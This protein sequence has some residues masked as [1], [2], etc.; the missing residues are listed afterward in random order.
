MQ[1]QHSD[2]E[3]IKRASEYAISAHKRIDQRRK[4]TG[5]PYH[6]HLKAV[7][8]TVSEAGGDAAQVAAAWLHDTVEDTPATFEDIEMEFGK[9]IAT[10][11]EELT[12][13]SRPGDGN[14][15]KRKKIDRKH[16]AGISPRA[17][18]IKLADLIDNARD[19]LKHDLKFAKVYLAEMQMLLEVLGEGDARLF[20]RAQNALLKGQKK[21]GMDMQVLQCPD[22]EEEAPRSIFSGF[23]HHAFKRM[24]F[25]T[26]SAYDIAKPLLAFD[27]QTPCETVLQ[28]LETRGF[29]LAILTQSGEYTGYVKKQEITE[30]ICQHFERPIS[31]NQILEVNA[32]ISEAVYT[33][34]RYDV[35]FVKLFDDI[36]AVIS[37]DDMNKPAA[38]MWL[39]GII[40]IMEADVTELIKKEYGDEGWI[41]LLAPARVK[42]AEALHEERKRLLQSSTLPECLQ[43]SDKGLIAS[44]TNGFLKS[45]G[46]T[47]KSAFK[48][49]LRDLELLRNNLAHSQNIGNDD[50]TPIARLAR[51]IEETIKNR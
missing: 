13:V 15:A 49:T 7:S 20:K 32:P 36:G 29:D 21:I 31:A 50:W 23:E 46:F 5:Q 24:F 47:T 38:K 39:F 3:I 18:T 2:D 9:D 44:E 8:K 10:L 11:V 26:F 22:E 16:L 41:P 14:R 12:D 40:T 27:A 43:L 28:A 48:R 33:L 1:K 19:I 6:V 34:T 30:G 4:Y 25:E 42:K 35:A 51:T 37:R 17:K 45:L